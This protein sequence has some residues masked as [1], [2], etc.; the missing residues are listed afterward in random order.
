MT[1]QGDTIKRVVGRLLGLLPTSRQA[2]TIE[3]IKA[4]GHQTI[5]IGGHQ[6]LSD[7]FEGLI[8]K[9]AVAAALRDIEE[10]IE[11][12][13]RYCKPPGCGEGCLGMTREHIRIKRRKLGIEG[14][15]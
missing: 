12:H 2:A 9:D 6:V 14:E 15:A 3:R 5:T 7:G 1:I 11:R 10:G 4:R 8:P 13:L